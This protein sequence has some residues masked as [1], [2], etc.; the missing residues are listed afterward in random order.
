MPTFY[1]NYWIRMFV[2]VHR[3]ACFFCVFLPLFLAFSF[4]LGYFSILSR[5]L[6]SFGMSCIIVAY[7]FPFGGFGWFPLRLQ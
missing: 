3:Q 6:S 5:M 7:V 2:R 4:C 1:L